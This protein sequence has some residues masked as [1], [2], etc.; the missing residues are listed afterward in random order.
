MLAQ[1]LYYVPTSLCTALFALSA[2]NRQELRRQLRTTLTLSFVAGALGIAC[3]AAFG[4][5]LLGLF[6]HDYRRDASTLLVILAIAY[7]PMAIK[8]QYVAVVRV[9]QRLRRGAAIAICGAALE[10]GLGA[11]GAVHGGARGLCLGFLVAVSIEAL[12][13]GPTVVRAARGAP[14]HA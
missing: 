10:V 3:V 1:F 14:R 6:G 4:P 5:D 7:F 13:T 12:I 9:L 8:L 2:G 11:L